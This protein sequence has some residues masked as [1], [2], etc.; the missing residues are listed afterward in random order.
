MFNLTV[1]NEII[2]NCHSWLER[3]LLNF[4]CIINPIMPNGISHHYQLEESI[5]SLK[6]VGVV[7]FNSF[8][9]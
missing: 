1:V 5:L 8:K 9:F 4:F 3:Y 7:S 2:C 6:D